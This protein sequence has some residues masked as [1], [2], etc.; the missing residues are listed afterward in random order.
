MVTWAC[1]RCSSKGRMGSRAGPPSTYSS[2]GGTGFVRCKSLEPCL[3]AE[4]VGRPPTKSVVEQGSDGNG[5]APAL[6]PFV[7]SSLDNNSSGVYE[8]G[9]SPP[10]KEVRGTGRQSQGS[11]SK[12]R[13][14][15]Q[16]CAKAKTWKGKRTPTSAEPKRGPDDRVSQASAH[17]E[18]EGTC[19]SDRCYLDPPSGQLPA[20]PLNLN[21]ECKV[22]HPGSDLAGFKQCEGA[23]SACQFPGVDNEE[24]ISGAASDEL[25]NVFA[26]T[27]VGAEV[28]KVADYSI[29]A[30]PCIYP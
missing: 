16:A 4:I 26:S 27:A 28:P 21:E 23:G 8:G 24:Q 3:A 19:P 18:C 13:G 29:W 30:I 15:A 22:Q 11:I 14:S 2:H 9:G 12:R 20:S 17:K 6:C 10:D 7:C 1:L 25:L 5:V